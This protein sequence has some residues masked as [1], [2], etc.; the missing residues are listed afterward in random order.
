MEEY[1]QMTN[2]HRTLKLMY[3]QKYRNQSNILLTTAL[4][5]DFESHS[6]KFYRCCIIYILTSNGYR[7][8][9]LNLQRALE[10]SVH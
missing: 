6:V 10:I 7:T 9:K 3:E 2:K 4:P 5:Q 8:F 1:I